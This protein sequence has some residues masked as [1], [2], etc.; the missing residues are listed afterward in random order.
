MKKYNIYGIG[1][2][3]VDLETEVS[4]SFLEEMKIHKGLMCL[5]D[6]KR[7]NELLNALQNKMLKKTC[8][9][10][11]ANTV[12]AAAQL[13][14]ENFYSCKV[15]ND[16]FGLFYKEDLLKNGVDCNRSEFTQTGT[17][18]KCLVLV[19][20]DAE[21]TMNT[22]LG[23]TASF[24][25]KEINE[26]ALKDSE[27]IY[28]EGYLVPSDSAVHAAIKARKIARENGVKVALT[29]SDSNMV[30]FFRD[31]LQNIIA[32]KV[33][34]LF[35]NEREANDWCQCSSIEESKIKMKDYAHSFAITLGPKGAIVYD[36]KQFFD[37]PAPKVN[38]VDSNGAGDMFAG[39]FLY[40]ITHGMSYYDS[41]VLANR[42]ASQVVCQIGARLSTQSLKNIRD[43]IIA[44][45]I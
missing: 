25:E 33:D 29:L 37:I 39:T 31:R 12:I 43:E 36:G 26:E 10:S 24:S 38:P 2:A 1:N 28:I 16:E 4:N 3:L 32:D 42:A 20:P 21:R 30:N 13:G 44:Q 9:G 23:I 17:T 8:G 45:R 40:G 34:M 5:V 27:F 15:A 11:A 41:G 22:F 35:C 14:A 6:E 19:T 7:Q 18:G